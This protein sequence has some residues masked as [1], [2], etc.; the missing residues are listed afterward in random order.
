MVFFN[1]EDEA[2]S[3]GRAAFSGYQTGYEGRLMHSLK[4]FLGS[5]LIDVQTEVGLPFRAFLSY[6]IG[7]LEVRAGTATGREFDSVVLGRP[8][9]FVDDDPTADQRAEDT[10]AKIARS[11]GFKDI[12]FQYEPIATAFDYE[13]TI[14]R[15]ELVLTADRCNEYNCRDSY[16]RAQHV[17]I[18]NLLLPCERLCGEDTGRWPAPTDPGL[19]R[20]TELLPVCRVDQCP[21][22]G[23]IDQLVD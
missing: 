5:S 11:V 3:F 22:F 7:E 20:G 18:R 16:Q 14:T 23:V 8:M 6:F 9:F 19:C 2:F 12:A 1:A 4:S 21:R 17:L 10:L 13:S 15:K